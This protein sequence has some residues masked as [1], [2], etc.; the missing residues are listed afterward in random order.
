MGLAAWGSSGLLPARPSKVL[1]VSKKMRQFSFAKKKLKLFSCNKSMD[2]SE[3]LAALGLAAMPTTQSELE[4]ALA[5]IASTDADALL[6]LAPAAP[7]APNMSAT[8]GSVR[9]RLRKL[10]GMINSFQYN[11]T[12]RKFLD[13]KKTEGMYRVSRTAKE[14]ISQALPIKCVEACFLG[15]YLTVGVKGLTRLPVATVSSRP[16]SRAP[17]SDRRTASSDRS[18]WMWNA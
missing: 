18:S 2:D 11:H 17:P 6:R 16:S 15:A 14:I 5:A 8:G 9:A 3:C 4:A 10:Q 1:W 12:G 7:C 13:L